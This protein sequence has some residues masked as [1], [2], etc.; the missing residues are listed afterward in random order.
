MKSLWSEGGK[1]LQR[2]LQ[3][4][5]IKLLSLL[6]VHGQTHGN[7]FEI[8]ALNTRVADVCK[9]RTEI[10][11]NSKYKNSPYYKAAKLWDTL[12][13]QVKDSTTLFELKQHLKIQYPHFVD[14]FY[15]V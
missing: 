5:C 14:D 12:P 2:V 1:G 15:L 7:V 4:C 9:F 10:Y 3:R 13:R 6:F 8:P 11:K